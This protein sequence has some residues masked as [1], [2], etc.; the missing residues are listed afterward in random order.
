MLPPVAI[1]GLAVA[2]HPG[3]T[4]AGALLGAGTFCG[5]LLLIRLVAGRE[6]ATGKLHYEPPEDR[7]TWWLE[8]MVDRLFSR[9]SEK[10]RLAIICS[11]VPAVSFVFF[12]L[13]GGVI[14]S[15][16]A[17]ILI[18]AITCWVTVSAIALLRKKPADAMVPG[19]KASDSQEKATRH[20]RRHNG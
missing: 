20:V 3:A 11:L 12:L 14:R 5:M 9:F 4:V 8:W 2:D 15:G 17:G 7:P 16:A 13:R 1:I 18:G 10:V 19:P 6:T